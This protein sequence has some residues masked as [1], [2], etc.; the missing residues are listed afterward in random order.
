MDSKIEKLLGRPSAR[1]EREI[2]REI[3]LALTSVRG[4]RLWRIN[5]G[6]AWVGDVTPLPA[7]PG[8]RSVRIDNAR[9]FTTGVPAGF[10]DLSGFIQLDSGDL[11]PVFI[12]VKTE[13]G[14]LKP[15]QESFL[16]AM[17]EAGCRAGVARSVEDALR[18]V[19]GEIW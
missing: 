3:Q 6:N 13:R 2:Q 16:N 19:R 10:P 17:R 9:P 4:L 5:V 14:R 11:I 8:K 12:E 15:A 18:I 7:P 1:D